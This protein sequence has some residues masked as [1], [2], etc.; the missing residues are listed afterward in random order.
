MGNPAITAA[1]LRRHVEILAS[2]QFA[3]RMTGTIGELKAT[4]Y[5]AEEF[6]GLELEPAGENNTYFQQ[7]DFTAGM[8]IEKTSTL[9]L[10]GP[11]K[12]IK[13]IST[14]IIQIG[15][16]LLGLQQVRHL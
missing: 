8:E 2:P 10:D 12:A 16:L 9:K 14:Q 4:Q 3:G 13:K 1:D 11:R 5:V 6:R 7:F 15:D